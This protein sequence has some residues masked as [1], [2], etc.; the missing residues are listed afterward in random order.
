MTPTVSGPLV[1]MIPLVN[2]PFVVEGSWVPLT[3]TAIVPV[4]TAGLPDET[5]V[6]TFT[7]QVLFG[8]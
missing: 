5:L 7:T 4:A 8:S 6:A 2:A 3:A 1:A